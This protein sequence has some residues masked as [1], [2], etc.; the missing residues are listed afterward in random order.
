MCV[1]KACFKKA[2]FLSCL[3]NHSPALGKGLLMR[4][5]CSSCSAGS[6]RVVSGRRSLE[7][8]VYVFQS[9]LGNLGIKLM[10]SDSR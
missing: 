1:C 9:C 7:K 2:A 8:A 4:S 5:A 10:E 3:R 6:R